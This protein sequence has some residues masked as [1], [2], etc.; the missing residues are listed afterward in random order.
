MPKKIDLP[1]EIRDFTNEECGV[2]AVHGIKHAAELAYLGLYALQHRGQES[3]G[4]VSRV[5]KQF[6]VVKEMGLVSDIFDEKSTAYLKG[7]AAIG[8]VRYSTTGESTDTNIQPLLA[9]TAKGKIAIAH[10]GN[11]TNAYTHYKTLKSAGALFQSTV[12][13]EVILHL[14][15]TAKEKSV[16]SAML[17]TL[18]KIEGAYSLVMLGDNYLMAAR[19]PHGF[20]PLVI[21]KLKDGF[22]ISS[23]TCALDLIGA[24]YE[25]EVQPGELIYIDNK[26]MKSY[27]IKKPTP[28]FCVFEHVYFARPDSTIFGENVHLVRKE[29]GRV[30]ARECPVDADIV[31]AI[32]DSGNSAALGYSEESGIPFEFGMT[33]NHYVG[34]TFIQ[35]KQS[36]RNLKVRVKLNPISPTIKGK[37]IIVIDDSIVRGTT[38]KHRIQALK[39]AGAKEIHVRIS[40]PPIT[41]PCHFGIDTPDKQDLIAAKKSVEEIR[42]FIGCDSLAYLS[43]DGMLSAI[44]EVKSQNFCTACFDGN[45]P[46][47]VKK[48]RKHIFEKEKIKQYGQKNGH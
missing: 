14:L 5:G 6:Y 21:G 18:A 27:Q 15:S 1:D 36:I 38:S 13:S 34:R 35:P 29:F 17:S 47:K 46:I 19:D 37:R 28:A 11:L 48:R 2:F 40:S 3:A 12:D 30:L 43:R 39:R 9:K 4:I 25:C 22:V 42:E 10:N 26:G 16:I 23:E 8:H 31:I 33:R 44:K 41:G 32:P 20:R 24:K 7:D 45:Y